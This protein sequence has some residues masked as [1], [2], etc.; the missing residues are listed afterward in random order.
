MSTLPNVRLS[1]T[2]YDVEYVKIKRPRRAQRDS[3]NAVSTA[4]ST[5]AVR[6]G[7]FGL[8]RLD[9]RRKQGIRLSYVHGADPRVKVEARGREW[10]YD[11]DTA[12]LD[13]LADVCNRTEHRR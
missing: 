2:T 12:V 3:A 9:W 13:I 4:P 5:P 10:L 7:W 11:W 6:R 1:S 8:P